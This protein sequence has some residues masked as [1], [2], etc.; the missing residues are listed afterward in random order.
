MVCAEDNW[1]NTLLS[2]LPLGGCAGL[3]HSATFSRD[4]C[5][6]ILRNSARRLFKLS[7]Q[8][9]AQHGVETSSWQALLYSSPCAGIHFF[10]PGP[11]CSLDIALRCLAST[12]TL[13]GQ[14][15]A[16]IPPPSTNAPLPQPS[17]MAALLTQRLCS[18]CSRPCALSCR[19]F[20]QRIILCGCLFLLHAS[21]L[22]S[23]ESFLLGP[24]AAESFAPTSPM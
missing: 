5:C 11:S 10:R 19:C 16:H 21:S 12:T 22:L 24:G 23:L 3:T 18:P 2:V 13:Q 15:V 6:P 7:P 20:L 8:S 1:N 4:A 14:T 17:G 9:G